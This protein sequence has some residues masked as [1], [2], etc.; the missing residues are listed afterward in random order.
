[1]RCDEVDALFRF[2]V[3]MTIDVGA[4]QKSLRQC[5][6]VS[7]VASQEGAHVVSEVP[8]P[9]LPMISEET[10]DLVEA[11]GIPSLGNQLGTAEY[12]IRFNTCIR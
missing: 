1:M 3:A 10:A 7:V 5:S 12:R 4:C 9:L 8:V 2:P 11:G 6:G